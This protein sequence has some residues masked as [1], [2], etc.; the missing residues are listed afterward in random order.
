MVMR[1]TKKRMAAGIVAAA[2][3]LG[4]LSGCSGGSGAANDN[5]G[6]SAAGNDASSAKE[7]IVTFSMSEDVYTW[8][9][10]G[11]PVVPFYSIQLL[12]YDMLVQ[13]DHEGSYEPALATEWSVSDD[14]LDWTFHL[15]QDVTFHNGEPFNA[16]SVKAT[17]E[18]GAFDNTLNMNFLWSDI[19]SVEE[20]DEYTAIIHCKKPI[21]D[22][23][24]QLT[25]MPMLP[26][27]ALEE[28]AEE[29]FKTNPGTGPWKFVSWDPGNEIVFVRNDDYWDWGDT[30]SNVDKIIYKPIS[31][32]TT[33][34]SSMR[35]GEFDL[36][37]NIPPDQV[38]V[39]AGSEGVVI[40]SQPGTTISWMALQSGAGKPFADKNVRLAFTHSID[41]EL[42]VESIL[43]SGS[44]A[45]W[46]V[47]EGVTGYDKDLASQYNQYDPELAKQLLADSGYNGEEIYFMAID[48]KVPRTKEVL[49]AVM[50]MMT[51][52]GFNVKLEIMEGATFVSKRSAGDYDIAFSNVFYNNG[53][54]WRHMITHWLSDSCNTELENPEITALL[55]EAKETIDLDK[56]NELLKQAYTLMMEDGGR[57]C[58]FINLDTINA[59]SDKISGVEMY[60]DTIVDLSRIMKQ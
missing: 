57:I 49:Q 9:T 10:M 59:H 4:A 28:N 16:E 55:T 54:P 17:L 48:G 41:R 25:Y 29:M 31:E 24:N 21:G 3:V 5:K 32:D 36:I 23:L 44:S 37:S 2:M 50:S 20:V 42:I 46:P 6:N 7:T 30:K 60:N 18:R 33:R 8:D 45:Y 35:T 40:D 13:T 27:K 56:Q 11:Q 58:Y 19:E 15:R 34:V 26:P 22:M 51:E 52:A 38:E 53:S 39:L 47:M 12:I 43:G 14:G 1:K